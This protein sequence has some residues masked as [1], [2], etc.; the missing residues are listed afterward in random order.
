MLDLLDSRL[1]GREGSERP[2][3]NLGKSEVV[4]LTGIDEC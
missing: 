4:V 3:E 1:S 2:Y